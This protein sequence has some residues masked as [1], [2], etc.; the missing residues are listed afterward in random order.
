VSSRRA[1][2]R[3]RPTGHGSSSGLVDLHVRQ[4]GAARVRDGRGVGSGQTRRRSRGRRWPG[5]PWGA[6]LV[7]SPGGQRF[8]Q[9]VPVDL[10]SISARD[11]QALAPAATQEEAR[12]PSLA[13]A[14]HQYGETGRRE[15]SIAQPP[16]ALP[17]DTNVVRTRFGDPDTCHVWDRPERESGVAVG[18]WSELPHHDRVGRLVPIRNG[19]ARSGV[20]A[21]RGW[22]GPD[23][24]GCAGG[25]WSSAEG[26]G[27]ADRRPPRRAHGAPTRGTV[28]PR[29]GRST[30]LREPISG[31]A[32]A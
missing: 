6:R 11:E 1:E 30:W 29:I 19:F 26:A 12:L 28:A 32:H 15:C 22:R 20:A 10:Q 14:G 18:H 25:H 17:S 13:P 7:G 3:I 8:V 23:P 24:G 4:P 16:I 9:P 21:L 31:V 27:R 5:A 2:R